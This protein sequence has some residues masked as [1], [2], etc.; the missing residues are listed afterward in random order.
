MDARAHSVTP[1]KLLTSTK[2]SRFEPRTDRRFV[3]CS[4]TG[5]R[6]F[7]TKAW[8]RQ[9]SQSGDPRWSIITLRQRRFISLLMAWGVC[10]LAKRNAKS[11]QGMQSPYRLAKHI[12]CGIQAKNRCACCAVAPRLTSTRTQLLPSLAKREIALAALSVQCECG[13]GLAYVST[14]DGP[15]FHQAILR[16]VCGGDGLA[17]SKQDQISGA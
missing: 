17:G 3:N 6:V 14:H 7:A 5:I 1:W 13:L 8:P 4:R 16:M 12:N 15:T 11:G 2:R 9:K 10:G